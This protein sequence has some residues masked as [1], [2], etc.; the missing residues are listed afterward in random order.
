MQKDYS[1][2]QWHKKRKKENLRIIV[3]TIH[4]CRIRMKMC[5]FCTVFF[6]ILLTLL[7][8]VL[9]PIF[10]NIEHLV[11]LNSGLWYRIERIANRKDPFLIPK[12]KRFGLL[13]FINSQREHIKKRAK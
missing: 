2:Y 3:M 5:A 4:L 1:N 10:I 6:N 11:R 12:R 9:Q 8:T 7:R 13:K